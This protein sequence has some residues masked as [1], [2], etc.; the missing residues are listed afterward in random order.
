MHQTALPAG[1]WCTR[2][3]W[4]CPAITISVPSGMAA[5]AA[6]TA[7]GWRNSPKGLPNDGAA[8]CGWPAS[9]SSRGE[10]LARF[11]ME[12]GTMVAWV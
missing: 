2:V 4:V 1:Q 6:W 9:S 12:P 11:S 8:R 7:S 10:S 3:R 5:K